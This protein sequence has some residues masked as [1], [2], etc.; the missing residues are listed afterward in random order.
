M[1]RKVPTNDIEREVYRKYMREYH[2]YRYQSDPIYRQKQ[3]DKG[4]RR[5]NKLKTNKLENKI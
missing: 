4:L 5:Y 1:P 2:K 3:I